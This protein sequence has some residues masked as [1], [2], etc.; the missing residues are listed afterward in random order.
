LRKG[1][2]LP[3]QDRTLLANGSKNAAFRFVGDGQSPSACSR[4]EIC[5]VCLVAAGD[6]AI[7]I[8]KTSLKLLIHFD[9][10]VS[11]VQL[12]TCA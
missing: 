8:G 7:T 2:C 3:Q 1:D 4:S 9:A 12:Q 5:L 6:Y 10:P 11:N